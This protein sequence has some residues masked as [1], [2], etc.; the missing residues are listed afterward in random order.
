MVGVYAE[1]RLV[2]AENARR[3]VTAISFPS[4]GRSVQARTVFGNACT[5]R[6]RRVRFDLKDLVNRPIAVV[7]S[8]FNS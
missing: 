8:V 5:I 2:S 1:R 4:P 7:H 6:G 3:L